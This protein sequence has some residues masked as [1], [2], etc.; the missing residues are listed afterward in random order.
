M[1]TMPIAEAKAHFT[2]AVRQVEQ[3]EAIIVTR[4]ASRQAVAAIIPIAEYRPKPGIAFGLAAGWGE[5]GFSDDWE[6]SDEELLA[7]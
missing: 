2:Q 6:V 4:G 7:S 3:G 5:I 1:T